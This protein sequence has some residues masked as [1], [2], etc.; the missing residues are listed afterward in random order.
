MDV[1]QSAIFPAKQIFFQIQNMLSPIIALLLVQAHCLNSFR[2]LGGSIKAFLSLL[3]LDGFGLKIIHM[4][5]RPIL[6]W[7]GLLPFP[8]S[9]QVPFRALGLQIS[10]TAGAH[11]GVKHLNSTW[12][13]RV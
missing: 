7:D 12:T 3:C 4:P 6:G 8:V 10:V 1:G 13:L 2:Q 5:K 11:V 9:R